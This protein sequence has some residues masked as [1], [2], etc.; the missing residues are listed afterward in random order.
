MKVFVSG[1][2]GSGKTTLARRISAEAGIPYVDFDATWNYS[3]D[4]ATECTTFLKKLPSDFVTDAVPFHRPRGLRYPYRLFSDWVKTQEDVEVTLAYCPDSEEWLRRVKAKKFFGG[5]SEIH[6]RR[7]ATE[8]FAIQQGLSHAVGD[9]LRFYDSRDSRYTDQQA[10]LQVP[11][12]QEKWQAKQTLLAHLR[13]QSYDKNYQDIE[14]LHRVG[15]S[16][17]WKTWDRLRSLVDWNN[18]TVVDLGCFHGYFL[19][20]ACHSG[21]RGY[22]LDISSKVLQTTELINQVQNTDA[23]FMEW[24]DGEDIPDADIILCL[25]V[26][27]H[28]K[29]PE[30]AL[31]K[32]TA[33]IAIFEATNSQRALIEQYFVIE[34][35]KPSHRKNRTILKGSR[36]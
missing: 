13:N 5:A 1:I 36:K 21:A 35:Q 27:H 19:F 26:L 8:V 9:Q 7:Y 18:Q 33:P 3:V 28:F 14:C 29:D 4:G 23:T 6:L 31:S 22:G 30:K 20:K 12:W 10:F 11:C 25:N 15:Y 32:F 24:E 16:E 2:Y 17:S 34:A